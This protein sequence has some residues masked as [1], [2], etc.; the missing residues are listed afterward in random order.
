MPKNNTPVKTPLSEEELLHFRTL[1]LSKR[2]EILGD[3]N[4]IEKDTLKSRLGESSGDLSSM[5]LHMADLGSDNY[6]QDYAINLLQSERDLLS[7]I[8]D[9]LNKIVDK[10][11][12]ICE[13]TQ[14]PIGMRRLEAKPWAK[15]C[16]EYAK[17]IEKGV[18]REG[19]KINL[20]EYAGKY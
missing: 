20:D 19:E 6:T 5:P 4:Q 10:T 12:G 18:V 1:L 7:E 2:A 17:L 15:Y 8:T 16:I 9:A 14:R 11:Y 13:G 3:F